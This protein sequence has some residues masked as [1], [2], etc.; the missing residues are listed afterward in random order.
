MHNKHSSEEA[1]PDMHYYLSQINV[2]Q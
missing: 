1:N 2:Q